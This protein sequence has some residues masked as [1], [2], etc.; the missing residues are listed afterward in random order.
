MFILQR[1]D[2]EHEE[3]LGDDS[4]QDD[5]PLIS[6]GQL[7]SLH[8]HLSNASMRDSLK[9][10]VRPGIPQEQAD[11]HDYINQD[12]LDEGSNENSNNYLINY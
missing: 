9:M 10:L 8:S 7:M 4:D 6:N 1:G 11:S 5:T 3:D 2:E 12:A